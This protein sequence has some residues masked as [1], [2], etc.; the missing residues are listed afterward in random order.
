MKIY[1]LCNMTAY[2][3]DMSIYLGKGL[4]KLNTDDDSNTCNIEVSQEEWKELARSFAWTVFC[5][6]QIYLIVCTLLLS[7]IIIKECQKGTKIETG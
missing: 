4:A 1:K 7:D 3:Y 6:L 5:P 2:T